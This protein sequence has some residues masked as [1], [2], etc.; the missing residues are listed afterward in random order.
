MRHK[1]GSYRWIRSRAFIL[2]D[3]AGRIYRKAGSHEDITERKAAEEQLQQAVAEL[4]KYKKATSE[5]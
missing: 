3:A 2:R 1:D 4:S 5:E